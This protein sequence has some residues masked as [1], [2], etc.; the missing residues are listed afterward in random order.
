MLNSHYYN[1]HYYCYFLFSYCYCILPIIYAVNSSTIT[2]II[3][4]FMI[5][6]S[7]PLQPLPS[8]WWFDGQIFVEASGNRSLLRP[9][10]EEVLEVFVEEANKKI[11][12]YNEMLAEIE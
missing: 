1:Y 6:V 10:I 11:E 2:I 9:D 12:R 7:F 3:R 4:L 8:G 5:L